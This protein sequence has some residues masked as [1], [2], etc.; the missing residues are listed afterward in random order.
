MAAQGLRLD[1]HQR[2]RGTADGCGQRGAPRG[3]A[4]HRAAP[5]IPLVRFVAVAVGAR[6]FP[7]DVH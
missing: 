5:R 4:D 3:S 1:A 6:Q 2:V 7:M